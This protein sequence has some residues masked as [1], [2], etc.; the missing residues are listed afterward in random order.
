[1]LHYNR[2][3]DAS[4]RALN[5]NWITL[6]WVQDNARNLSRKG[7]IPQTVVPISISEYRTISDRCNLEEERAVIW[8]TSCVSS[9]PLLPLSTRMYAEAILKNECI[10][11][12][13]SLRWQTNLWLASSLVLH[14]F[15]VYICDARCVYLFRVLKEFKKRLILPKMFTKPIPFSLRKFIQNYY[16]FHLINKKL[17]FFCSSIL[18]MVHKKLSN[19]TKKKTIWLIIKIWIIKLER[20]EN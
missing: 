3:V 7:F 10:P 11:P 18:L 17:T 19:S 15:T 5:D 20:C 14:I 13:Q 1:M 6:I 4:A 9:L 2:T 16:K 12:Y 8:N